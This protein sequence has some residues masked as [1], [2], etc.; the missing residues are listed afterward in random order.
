MPRDLPGTHRVV[1]RSSRCSLRSYRAEDGNSRAAGF[2]LRRATPKRD[3]SGEGF[4]PNAAKVRSAAGD[5]GVCKSVRSVGQIENSSFVACLGALREETRKSSCNCRTP[6]GKNTPVTYLALCRS[7]SR[8][9]RS[10]TTYGGLIQQFD[11][12]MD[13]PIPLELERDQ[14]PRFRSAVVRFSV[15]PLGD[16]RGIGNRRAFR[17]RCQWCVVLEIAG[18]PVDVRGAIGRGTD[19]GSENFPTPVDVLPRRSLIGSLLCH[20]LVLK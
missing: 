15:H 19:Q 1:G 4:T 8:H 18:E 2:S 7:A 6:L 12:A 16:G 5:T 14:I 10:A 9:R 3:G 20:Q 11:C 17:N 13:V